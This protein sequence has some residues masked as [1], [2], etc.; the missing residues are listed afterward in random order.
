[1]RMAGPSSRLSLHVL[2]RD[3]RLQLLFTHFCGTHISLVEERPAERGPGEISSLQIRANQSSLGERGPGE[4]DPL[5]IR[6]TEIGLGEIS[7]L[8][9][10]P[11]QISASEIGF[12]QFGTREQSM[13][14][15]CPKSAIAT[16]SDLNLNGGS[17]TTGSFHRH[18]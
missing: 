3:D 18:A 14:Q 17:V 13:R 12:S 11:A 10:R 16:S 1:M 4:I 15:V 7:S 9:I 6:I 2:R 5:H 8:Q